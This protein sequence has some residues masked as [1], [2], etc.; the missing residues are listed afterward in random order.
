MTWLACTKINIY[1]QKMTFRQ[2]ISI[3]Q[4]HRNS[5]HLKK[6]IWS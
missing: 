4:K 5:L 2:L 6:I 3:I 1:K